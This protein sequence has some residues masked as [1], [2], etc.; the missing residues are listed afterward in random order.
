MLREEKK[1]KAQDR[2]GFDALTKKE[3]RKQIKP[4]VAKRK[5]MKDES[6]VFMLE[7]LQIARVDTFKAL[8]IFSHFSFVGSSFLNIS[9][10][11]AF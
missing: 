5:E 7:S 8:K 2:L 11:G 4:K 6:Q 1:R 10:P 3:E 9:F